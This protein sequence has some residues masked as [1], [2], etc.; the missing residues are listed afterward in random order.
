MKM[1]ILEIRF[2]MVNKLHLSY[3][4]TISLCPRRL[5]IKRDKNKLMSQSFLL[6]Y[7]GFSLADGQHSTDALQPCMLLMK[8][9][10]AVVMKF[11]GDVSL[12][13]N[14]YSLI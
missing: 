6:G 5:S 3:A 9:S 11:M 7:A 8:P 1:G 14:G 4:S 2:A 10:A 13:N 12:A